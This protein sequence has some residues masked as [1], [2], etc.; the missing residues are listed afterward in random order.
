M[1]FISKLANF[2]RKPSVRRL[3][4]R[5]GLMYPVNL[6]S[7]TAYNISLFFDFL[8]PFCKKMG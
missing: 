5:K 1:L 2:D 8:L 6:L 4:I 3:F 7:Q